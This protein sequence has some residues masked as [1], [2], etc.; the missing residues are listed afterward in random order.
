ML[1]GNST[2]SCNVLITTQRRDMVLFDR[3]EKNIYTLELTICFETNTESTHER[4]LARYTHLISDMENVGSN[5]LYFAIEI[6]LLLKKRK[7]TEI[8]L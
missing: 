4:K 7:T 5:I 8:I 2:I 3:I 6:G 1:H